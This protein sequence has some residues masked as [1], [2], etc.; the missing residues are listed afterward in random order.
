MNDAPP[1]DA[2]TVQPPGDLLS[3]Y[4][5]FW[6]ALVGD[7]V[8]GVGNNAEAAWLAARQSRPRE[9]ISAVIWVPPAS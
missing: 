4:Q 8:A 9:R 6:V 5:G 2:Q 7:Q 1:P 3:A